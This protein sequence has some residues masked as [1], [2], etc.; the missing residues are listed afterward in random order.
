MKKILL[1]ALAGIVV[2]SATVYLVRYL[3]NDDASSEDM[4]TP[5][6]PAAEASTQRPEEPAN[7]N[8]APDWEAV[9]LISA[10]PAKVT[11]ALPPDAVEI[12]P[13][14]ANDYYRFS[15]AYLEKSRFM[16]TLKLTKYSKYDADGCLVSDDLERVI[17][18]SETVLD[19]IPFCVQTGLSAGAG[20]VYRT[21]LYSSKDASIP[22]AIAF[23]IH[24]ASSVQLYA[25]CETEADLAKAECVAR[26]FHNDDMKLFTN[27]IASFNVVAPVNSK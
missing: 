19:G 26:E 15:D 18:T 4:Q 17:E 11:L 27:I 25:G 2:V 13:N 20:Q 23:S 8:H 9:E 21:L 1:S 7:A 12:A 10:F 6:T 14:E 3:P 5:S 24:Y 16:K 22:V